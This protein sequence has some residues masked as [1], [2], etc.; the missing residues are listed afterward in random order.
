MAKSK[1]HKGMQGGK[2]YPMH[3]KAEMKQ[4]GGGKG[5]VGKPSAEK[6]HTKNK[7]GKK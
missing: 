3:G 2:E 6:M 7:T 5:M 4:M 1:P